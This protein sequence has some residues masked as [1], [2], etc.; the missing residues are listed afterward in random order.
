MYLKQ[1]ELENFKSFKG[2]LTIPLMEGYLA[3]TGPNGSGKSN[4]TDAILFVLGPKSS[5]AIRAGK[6]TDLIFDGGTSKSGKADSTRVSLVFDNTDRMIPLDEDIVKLTRFVRITQDGEGYSSHFYVNDRKSTLTEFDALLTRA[7]ISAD[8]YNLVQQGDVLRIVQ[9]GNLERRRVLDS[10]SGIASFD[11]DLEKAGRERTEAE[12]NVDRVS[13]IITELNTQLEQLEKDMVAA[14]KFLEAQ[15]QMEMAKAQMVHRNLESAEAKI[16]Y[17]KE[18][19]TAHA[20]EVEKLREKKDKLSS[21]IAEYEE[22]LLAKEREI[23][24]KVG[25]EYRELK[26]KI[27]G[28]KI[29]I[30]TIR[31]RAERAEDDI[32][33][34]EQII[35]EYSES[36]RSVESELQDS[37]SSLVRV[38]GELKDKSEKLATAKSDLEKLRKDISSAGGEI[39][40]LQTKLQ[41]T[42]EK[43]DKKSEEEKQAEI[44]V[45]RASTTAEEASLALSQ[46]EEQIQ[47]ADFEIND[48][49]W[50]L[51]ETKGESGV[52]DTRAMADRIMLAKKKEAELEK[53]ESEMNDAVARLS[54]EFERLRTEKRVTENL[55]Q[56]SEAVAAILALRDKGAMKGIH[57]TVA[58]LATV[59]PEYEVALSVAAGA[60]MQT[61]V[62]DDDQVASDAINYLKR[63]KLGRVR[64]LPISKVMEGKPR[65]KAI[66]IEKESIGYAIDLIRFD[67]RYKGV[68]WDVFN[69]TLVMNSLEDA[70]R[71]MGGVRLVTK[72]GE[73][74]EAGG[75]MVGGT[76]SKQAVAKFGPASETKMEKVGAELRAA[77]DSLNILKQQLRDLRDQ[78]RALDGEFR[79]VSTAS[80][81]IQGK[82]GKLEAQLNEVRDKKKRIVE[83]LGSKKQQLADA[84]KELDDA[85]SALDKVSAELSKLRDEKTSLRDRVTEMAPADIQERLQKTQDSQFDLES[86]VGLLTTEKATINAEKVGIEGQKEAILKQIEAASKKIKEYQDAVATAD[87]NISKIQVNLDALKKIEAE[88]EGGIAGLRDAK[89]DLLKKKYETENSKTS[90]MEKI[91]TKTDYA[92]GLEAQILITE[93]TVKQLKDEIALIGFEVEL[94]IPSEQE[95]QRT[96]KSCE[97]LMAKVGNVNLRA[98]EDYDEKKGRHTKLSDDV[99]E[100]NARIKELSG[101]MDSLNDDKKKLFM[102][103]FEGVS[104]H[105]TEVYAELS[106]GGEAMMKLEFP[107]SPFDGGLMINAKPRNG[108]MLRLEALSGGEKGLT[109]MAFIF[110]IQEYQPSPLYMFDEVDMN[111][112]SV[113]SELVARRIKK[114]STRAQFIQVSLRKVTLALAEHLIGV[115]RQPDGASKV[116]I[117]PDLAE[118]SKYEDQA[119]IPKDP[120]AEPSKEEKAI[121]EAPV[122]DAPEI[123]NKDEDE[124]PEKYYTDYKREGL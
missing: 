48:A 46:L 65:A 68:F 119:K 88:M 28:V 70:R 62:V 74:I 101:L 80:V 45:A 9:M 61:I 122:E 2:K 25:P 84:Q 47:H 8:G 58:E 71:V 57:G 85:Q 20:D 11:A 4:I 82:L 32:G 98:I 95:L 100:L 118:V 67:P 36:L 16:T 109:A 78:I 49:E 14:R 39:T 113:N 120:F 123:V 12:A 24:A 114:S 107:D 103:T 93:E 43:I 13:I 112:D 18:Q 105:F 86:E 104:K 63:E 7:R 87:E 55:S 54:I 53:Q 29:E 10:I 56:G 15:K 69:D 89:D 116:I 106:G 21:Q 59:D 115:T 75:A 51:K 72:A 19:I 52:G 76:L 3:V 31:D 26:D 17:T 96:I 27:E 117:Q 23:E 40:V 37:I 6:L 1:I 60:R 44:R 5:K 42:E 99:S 110:A 34:Q 102:E 66:M 22:G 79:N 35:S 64:F 91:E 111:L 73:M 108:K 77:T 41:E 97:G 81:D 30:A 38:E 83:N 92:S 33:E 50:N 124:R 90:V 94:P 121:R